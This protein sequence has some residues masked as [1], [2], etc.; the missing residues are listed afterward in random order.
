MFLLQ[1][2]PAREWTATLTGLCLYCSAYVSP[3]LTVA[4]EGDYLQG[5][6]QPKN[7]LFLYGKK[8]FYL[9]ACFLPFFRPRALFEI[10]PFPSL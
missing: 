3:L 2:L 6:K 1:Y 5:G 7:I 8:G 10:R 4:V 9:P